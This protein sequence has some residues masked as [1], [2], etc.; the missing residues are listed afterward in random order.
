MCIELPKAVFPTNLKA[1]NLRKPHRFL[2]AIENP[3]S[4]P[5][6]EKS[7]ELVQVINQ[8]K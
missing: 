5:M 1:P 3:A 8:Q 2:Q 7:K 4:I 6:L